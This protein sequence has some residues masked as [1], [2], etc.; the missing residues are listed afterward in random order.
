MFTADVE[1]SLSLQTLLLKMTSTDVQRSR[2][3]IRVCD[4]NTLHVDGIQ[5]YK[6]WVHLR[7]IDSFAGNLPPSTIMSTPSLDSSQRAELLS[8][9]AIF[10]L[11]LL[12][13]NIGRI[14]ILAWASVAILRDFA[15]RFSPS[16]TMKV[17]LTLI[18]T[19]NEVLAL[20]QTTCLHYRI[21][22]MHDRRRLREAEKH[23]SK[24]RC[25]LLELSRA[26]WPGYFSRT[27]A[28]WRSIATCIEEVEGIHNS[29]QFVL[30]AEV[31]RKLD[32]EIQGTH[33]QLSRS[34]PMNN[35]RTGHYATATTIT[36]M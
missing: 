1:P 10:L 25:E 12:P 19:T 21:P 26:S 18:A 6:A 8:S 29:I 14:G 35:A 3:V 34:G 16:D 36:S 33:W 24:L 27:Y 28:L 2:C 9:S 15:S 30:E 4:R 31:Q 7:S 23:V 22:L 13:N 11:A 17:L 20:A 32:D 5:S